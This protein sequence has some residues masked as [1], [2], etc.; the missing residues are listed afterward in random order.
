MCFR[1]P[2]CGTGHA[3]HSW[4]EPAGLKGKSI[5]ALAVAES[6]PRIL[7]AGAL[8]GLYRSK[9]SGNTWERITP[10]G[11]SKLK[12]FESVAIDPQDP[13]IIYAGTWHLPWKTRDGGVTWINIRHGV[14][15][16][17]DVFSIILAHSTPSTVF[18]SACSGIYKSDNG[19]HLFHKVQG[20]PG[21]ARRTRVLQQDP[22]NAQTVYAGTT[23]G[24]WKT[25][26][27][28]AHFRRITPADFILNDVL[29]DPRNSSHVLIAT[30]RSGVFSSDDAGATFKPSNDGFS[31]RQIARIVAGPGDNLYCCPMK[32]VAT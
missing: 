4:N 22:K 25:V 11:N 13:Q 19:G 21:T 8:D 24:L 14:I 9:D 20:I 6:N 28:G 29:V 31:E 23:E 32:E 15:D 18:A 16:D 17:S 10:A 12:N 30:D 26:D 2:C 3:G 27:G 5:Q 1:C 7:V